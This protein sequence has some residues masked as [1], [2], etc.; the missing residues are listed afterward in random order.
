MQKFE[1]SFSQDLGLEESSI[2]RAKVREIF[3]SSDEQAAVQFVRERYSRRASRGLKTAFPVLVYVRDEEGQTPI[4]S[5]E[6]S[7]L[8][9]EVV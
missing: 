3:A 2:D 4:F 7:G 8:R 1:V 6:V 9:A 5:V